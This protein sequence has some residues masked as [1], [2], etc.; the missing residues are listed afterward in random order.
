MQ[1]DILFI[2]VYFYQKLV[3]ANGLVWFDVRY[4]FTR[5]EKKGTQCSSSVS[6][7]IPDIE[8]DGIFVLTFAKYESHNFVLD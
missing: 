3:K 2:D 4:V 5:P 7:E 1:G 8:F 6:Q